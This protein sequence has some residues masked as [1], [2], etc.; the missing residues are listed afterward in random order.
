MR[1]VKVLEMLN[2]GKIDE[3]KSKLQNE[4]Y[5][6][7]LKGKPNAKKRYT[8]MKKYFSYTNHS[9]ECC[10]KPCKIKFEGKDYI[11]FTNSW[12]LVLTTEDTGEIELFDNKD[13]KYPDVTQLLRFDG[14]KRKVNFREIFAE[15]RS[16]G[17]KLTKTEIGPGFQYMIKYDGTYYKIGLLEASYNMIDDGEAAMVYHPDGKRRPLTIQTS[18]GICMIMPVFIKDVDEEDLDLDKVIEVEL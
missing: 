12:S 14:V 10:Q 16:R 18:V 15:A 9:R 4:I 7:S 13:N 3:L 6:D 5:A 8:A 11:S 1:S 17:Y 2:N